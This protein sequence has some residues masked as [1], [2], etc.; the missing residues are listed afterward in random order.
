M[1]TITNKFEEKIMKIVFLEPTAG[2]FGAKAYGSCNRL[3]PLG[4]EYLA[5]YLERQG[6]DCTVIQQQCRSKEEILIEIL[7]LSP[8]MLGISV[9]TYNLY[10][11]LWFARKTKALNSNIVTVFGGYHVSAP[12][13]FNILQKHK[14]VDFIV[15]GEGEET[16]GELVS[17][18]EDGDDNLQIPGLAYF[19]D[20]V[21]YKEKRNRITNL[22]NLPF[23]KRVSNSLPVYK[24]SGLMYPPPSRQTGVGAISATRGCLYNCMFCCSHTIWGNGIQRRSPVNVADEIAFLIEE[25]NVNGYFL[26][27]LTFNANKKYA[28]N[29]CREIERRDFPAYFYAMCN[30]RSMDRELAEAMAAAKCSKIGFGVESFINEVRINVKDRGG[31]D[32]LRTNQVFDDVTSAGI[33]IKAYFIIGFPGETKE[34]LELLKCDIAQL[35]ADDIRVTFYVPFPGTKGYELHRDRL[36]TSD[37]TKFTT[38]DQPVVRLETLKSQELIK[39][40]KDIF[41]EFFNGEVWRERIKQRRKD[42]PQLAE[43]FDEFIAYLNER[44]IL[45]ELA[46]SSEFP[47]IPRIHTHCCG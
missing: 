1:L 15:A 40:R 43:S 35:R 16:L 4:L 17:C 18:L 42:F 5:A 8:K 20:K 37:L 26:C 33:L 7:D 6:H 2:A 32:C 36:L 28:I 12:S 21:R 3:E 29:L 41:R 14:E 39:I 9:Q 47:Q 24:M 27:D 11:S 30:L 44:Q 22:D 46:S 25:H 34:S 45:K 19:D 23:P 38:L 10:E 31:L 13:E